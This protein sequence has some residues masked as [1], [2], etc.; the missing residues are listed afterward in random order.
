[1]LAFKALR[2][3][4]W[5]IFRYLKPYVFIH[6]CGTLRL[7]G[8]KHYVS[9]DRLTIEIYMHGRCYGWE[10]ETVLATEMSR[11]CKTNMHA[12]SRLEYIPYIG[13][14]YYA[15]ALYVGPS[16]R[17]SARHS[18]CSLSK[19]LNNTSFIIS[20]LTLCA[21]RKPAAGAMEIQHRRSLDM[22]IMTRSYSS[23]AILNC[24]TFAC[25]AVDLVSWR[26]CW[27]TSDGHLG[28]GA[29]VSS[30]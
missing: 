4:N 19:N 24:S 23:G 6:N 21:L 2:R 15:I 10:Y 18:V 26:I 9:F 14:T 1:M 17:L 3:I 27:P 22:F 5:I 30:E 29:F 8:S 20:S 12:N 7:H 25:G 16:V 13:V 11:I 28:F